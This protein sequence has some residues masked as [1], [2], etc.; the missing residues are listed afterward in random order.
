V[1]EAESTGLPP[2]S[3]EE[4]GSRAG[5]STAEVRRLTDLGL[6]KTDATGSYDEADVRRVQV[7]QA[8]ERA[9]VESTELA[10]LVR[11]GRFSLD[12]LERA[13]QRVFSALSEVSFAEV[14][15]RTGVPFDTVAVIRE[16]TGGRRP[17]PDDLVREDELQIVPLVRRQHEL[18]F[19]RQAIVR[20]I[21]VYGDSLRRIAEAEAEWWRSEVQEP[22]LAGGAS[23]D[24]VTRRSAE[25]SPELSHDADAAL[26][27]VYHAQQMLVW[28]TNL[29]DGITT[30]L[31]QVGMRRP[32]AALPA[33]CFLD[34]TGYTQLTQERGDDAAS[35]I[36]ERLNQV[37]REIAVHHRG[38]PAKWLGDGVMLYFPD[39]SDGVAAAVAMVDALAAAG[40]PPAHVGI[41]AGPVVLQQGDFFGHTVNLAARVGEYAR[42]GEVLVTRSLVDVV[43]RADLEFQS[44]GLV[45]LKGVAE[46]V[47]LYVAVARSGPPGAVRDESADR[48]RSW[49]RAHIARTSREKE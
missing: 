29:V 43:D 23:A 36:I 44:V 11:S 15:D 38:R 2:A 31:E 40:L 3:I 27:A 8:L 25:I 9:G 46:P 47:D 22:M 28:S 14:S 4:T 41:H 37:V 39:P 20:A 19:R 49:H 32:E 5:V 26:L 45:E 7:V 42:P 17:T 48:D 34:L 30:G 10:S 35:G 24:D 6:L 18:G 13:G 33:M 12:F 16:A 21:R 1:D